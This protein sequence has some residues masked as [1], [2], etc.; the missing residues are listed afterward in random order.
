MLPSIT[1]S[2]NKIANKKVNLVHISGYLLCRFPVYTVVN[3]VSFE[4]G[5]AVERTYALWVSPT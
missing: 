1:A 3:T 4:D 5:A 2:L